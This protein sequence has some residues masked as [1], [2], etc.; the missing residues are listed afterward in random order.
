MKLG[1][2]DYIQCSTT[3]LAAFVEWYSFKLFTLFPLQ[4]RVAKFLENY[5]RF[6]MFSLLIM[7]IATHLS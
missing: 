6:D 4:G 2:K 7:I 3:H 5:I 1:S